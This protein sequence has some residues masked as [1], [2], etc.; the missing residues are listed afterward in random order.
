V[1]RRGGWSDETGTI[2]G[3]VTDAK[4]GQ[5]VAGARVTIDGT[6]LR[7]LTND[8]GG[9]RMTNVPVG[10]YTAT[11]RRIGYAQG[12]A[13]VTVAADE[14]AV[15][16]LRLELSAS[17]LDAVVV[18]GTLVPTEVKALP[19][20]VSII[21]A[22]D[23]AKQRPHTVQELFRQAVPTGVAWDMPAYPT[24]TTFSVRGASNLVSGLGQMKVFVDGIPVASNT[25]ASVDPNS[26]ERVE[27]IRGPQAAAIYGSD[28]LGG[29]LQIFTKRG[30]SS[31]T[32]PVWD[33]E[34]A[35][36]AVQTPNAGYESVMRQAYRGSVAGGG[37]GV[38]YDF[39]AGYTH[40][41]DWVGPVSGQSQASVHGGVHVARG[42]LTAD[43]S[44]R[45]Y[46]QRLP[47]VYSP[48]LAATG[49]TYFSKPFYQPSM[50]RQQTL[51]AKVTLAPTRWWQHTVTIGF[52]RLNNEGVQTEP[53]LTTPNDTFF[54]AFSAEWTKSS[55][56]YNSSI[57]GHLGMT[58]TGSL[59]VGFDHYSLPF[60][61][62]FTAGA[63]STSA[64]T[65]K[66]GQAPVTRFVT[67]NTGYFAQAQLGFWDA[68]FL[69]GG[70]RAEK[71]TNFGD[72][73]GTPVSPQTG[74][75]Y[76]RALG[77]STLKLRASWGRA[78]RPPSSGA[79]VGST[80]PTSV[81]LPSPDLGPEQQRGW[82]AGVDAILGRYG[83]LSVTYFNQTAKDLIALLTV[84]ATT[85][86]L[87]YQY[88]NVG[89]VK[90]SGVEVEASVTLGMLDVRGQYG[91][92][93]SRVQDPGA[94]TGELLRGDEFLATP[95]HT[96]GVSVSLAPRSR[97]T[98]V[99]GVTYV[100]ESVGYDS[101]ALYRCLAGTG[102]C[103]S[104][105]GLRPYRTMLP[106]LFKVNATLSQQLPRGLTGF[107]SVDNVTNSTEHEFALLS[108]V[109]GRITTVGL[110]FHH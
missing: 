101:P 57:Q 47:T 29:V 8:S 74:L 38:S 45:Y 13:S 94:A 89:R 25:I 24:Q 51:G 36:G 18:A 52:D 41:P 96:G 64:S 27:V 3:R 59:T 17:P 106:S 66:F 97:T 77:S 72:A 98:L 12:A 100:G 62:W 82:D 2:T 70:V 76:V 110:Q 40:T 84:D 4:T 71:N 61:S 83:S 91:Y 6:G 10:T 1:T 39:G 31:I 46:G 103:P 55:I 49:Y 5:G 53:R 50:Y 9:F 23:F 67:D 43:V 109:M 68:L 15:V 58:G 69:T 73:I 16:E 35:F 60:S 102:P 30:D 107:V 22:E 93:H 85:T 7:A 54:T 99:A 48:E 78:I 32:R 87:T 79:K 28:A 86:P 90:N 75:T 44:G 65:G 34:A 63:L 14:E 19:T 80:S 81:I 37:P 33:G 20:P 92:V 104:G 11:A 108:A 105:P 95:T 42:I 88:Q 26:I 56:A 21:T